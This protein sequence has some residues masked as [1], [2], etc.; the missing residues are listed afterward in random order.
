MAPHAF[1]NGFHSTLG[2]VLAITVTVAVVSILYAIGKEIRDYIKNRGAK[3]KFV[4][5][6]WDKYI[7]KGYFE[8]LALLNKYKEQIKK[9]EWPDELNDKFEWSEFGN[10][11]STDEDGSIYYY[12]KTFLTLK[13]KYKKKE[14]K[15]AEAKEENK[16]DDK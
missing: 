15:E 16:E 1:Y 12:K 9:G 13:N 3:A 14:K 7:K 2:V 8:E 4:I 5:D 6:N 10:A 11:C